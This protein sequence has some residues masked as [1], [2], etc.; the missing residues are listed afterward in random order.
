MKFYD[1]EKE[2]GALDKVRQTAFSNHSVRKV[3]ALREKVLFKYE[4][5]S[6][7]FSMEEM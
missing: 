3:E 2:L 6:K 5:E 7:L 1:R 4:I